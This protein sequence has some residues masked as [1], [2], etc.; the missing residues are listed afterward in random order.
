MKVSDLLPKLV[1]NDDKVICLKDKDN[2][3]IIQF[4]PTGYVGISAE[5]NNRDISEITIFDNLNMICVFLE[6]P[7]DTNIPLDPDDLSGS[8]LTP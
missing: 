7:T 6:N 8:V 2:H 1:K 3:T 5:L 4:N